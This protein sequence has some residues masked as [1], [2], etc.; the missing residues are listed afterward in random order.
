MPRS[1]PGKQLAKAIQQFA[2]QD[3]SAPIGPLLLILPPERRPTGAIE[4][5]MSTKTELLPHARVAR[6]DGD[7]V[8]LSV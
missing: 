6:P 1:F 8:P 4:S 2:D 5:E 3:I 7:I